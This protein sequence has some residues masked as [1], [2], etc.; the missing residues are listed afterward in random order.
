METEVSQLRFQNNDLRKCVDDLK[1]NY[2]KLTETESIWQKKWS[3]S[4]GNIT[5]EMISF[6]NK[7]NALFKI[8]SDMLSKILKKFN[9]TN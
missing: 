1:G 3:N 9:E 6:D 7:R 2:N 5:Q 8:E 4:E